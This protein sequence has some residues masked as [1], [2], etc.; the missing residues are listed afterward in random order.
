MDH[1]RLRNLMPFAL[2][3]LSLPG[4]GVQ[5]PNAAWRT[6]ATAHYRI[7]YPPMLSDWAQDV[8]SSIEGIH[9]QVVALVG[10][11]SP[12]PIQ[13][14]LVDPAG[15]PNGMAVPL[16]PN[17]YLILWATEP[18]SD[19]FHGNALSS[20]T[21]ELVSHEMT[22]IHHLMRPMRART[23]MGNLFGLP[24]GPLVLKCPRWVSEGYA[25]LAE[26]RIT[27]SGRPH[28]AL[29]AALIRQW[30]REGKLPAYGSLD[31][32]QGFLAGNMAYLVGSTYLEWL[33]R[34]RPREPDVLKRLWKQLAS[35]R[36]RSFDEAFLATFGFPAADGYQRFQAEAAHDALEWELHMKAQGL[37]EGELFLRAGGTLRD[38][39]VSPDGTRLLASLEAR[40]HAGLRVWS[41]REKEAPKAHGKS[42]PLNA[43]EDVAPES[44][45]RRAVA[46]LPTLDHRLPHLAEWVDDATIR[47]QLKHADA[48]G[49]LHRRPALWRLGDGV[50]RAPRTLPPARW[51]TL[52][53]VHRAG[54]W[55]L[56][57]DGARA[58]LPGQAVGRA[59]VD[60][61]RGFL[62]AG[63]EV[64]GV[65][66]V[67]RAPFAREGGVPVFR[68]AQVM[69]R[70]VSG[71]WNPAPSPD[72][73]TLF[74]TTLDARGMEIR[75]LD[76][77]LPP[78][79]SPPAPEPR[80]LTTRAVMPPPVEAA[81]LPRAAGPAPSTPYRALENQ[82]LQLGSGA[83]LAPSGTSWQL[84]LAGAD[85]LR[86]FSW[87]ALAGFGDDAGPRGAVAG[88]SSAAWAWRPSLTVFS[89]TA[90]PSRQ[91]FA[92]AAADRR[93]QG[94]ELSF[95]WENSGEVPFWFSP[96]V[97]SERVE[98]L[99]SPDP[100][101][102]RSLLGLRAG[103]KA[104]W[105]R[106]AWGVA[107][108]PNLQWFPGVTTG[109]RTDHWN[110]LRADLALRLENPAVPVTLRT[111]GGRI[112]NSG[113]AGEAFHLG[114]SA[115][116]LVPVSLD[117]D[118][119]EQPALPEFLATGDRFLRWRGEV[120]GPVRAYL[121]GAA[122]WN[123]GP[124]RPPFQ[125]VAGLEVS[126]DNPLGAASE[127]VLRRM[128]LQAGVHRPLDGPMKNRTVATLTVVLR[129]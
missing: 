80:L 101:R 124:G 69:T 44:P 53:P 2:S 82:W 89:A 70:T 125:R 41:L 50:D 26:G 39:A 96:V 40:D 100:A 76:L 85:L 3:A 86:R 61:A 35:K 66:E 49:S 105:A 51:R 92:P 65:V 91:R 123:P 110:L 120:G 52:E 48:E 102:T 57:L 16:L 36:N 111:S 54:A 81:A 13:V 114:G 117:C 20:W 119:V 97:A 116:A 4:A 62:W 83:A 22:H 25:T 28:S 128:R 115:T 79:A 43:V 67:V 75:R 8:A 46:T 14:L 63:C 68:A 42:D 121:E 23:S 60:E 109:T 32:V 122:V 19:D 127:E 15:D 87:Q 27:G 34:Q 84:G 99:D 17:P 18:R 38:L 47:F 106:G 45:A 77:A 95:I 113:A 118:R 112:V 93:R 108:N 103:L 37:R 129:P 78:L 98:P 11:E 71:A 88:L 6:L 30:A 56:V 24:I 21:E 10:Y 90:R 1:A 29:R 73:K 107:F 7:H 59:F 104:L 9:V 12:G 33:E 5:A 64:D 55:E 74:F 58:P 72:G 31:Q 126:L 94:G